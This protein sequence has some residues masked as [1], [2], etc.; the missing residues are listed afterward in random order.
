MGGVGEE[1]LIL[2]HTNTS[3]MHC[4]CQL[5]KQLNLQTIFKFIRNNNNRMI[6]SAIYCDLGLKVVNV[7]AQ[8]NKGGDM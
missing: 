1:P 5:Y 3:V 2:L 7:L 6:L 8:E 4:Y